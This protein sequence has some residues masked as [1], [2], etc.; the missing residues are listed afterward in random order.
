NEILRT[1]WGFHGFVETDWGAVH[2]RVKGVNAGLN[3]EMPGSGAYNRKKIIEA[4][5][6]G[7]ITPAVL[8]EVVVKLLAVI[9][10]A[11]DRHRPGVMFDATQHDTL[12]RRAAGESL[13][14]LKNAG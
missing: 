6:A 13:V 3:L 7:D 10:D 4:V 9:L 5:Q 2:D 11:K 8:D 14:L 12:A 1:E